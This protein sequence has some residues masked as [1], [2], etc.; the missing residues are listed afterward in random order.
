MTALLLSALS[1]IL[2][3][4]GDFWG[5]L[6][7]RQAHVLRALPT[8]LISGTITIF[9]LIPW[10]GAQYTHGSIMAGLVAGTFGSAGFF[11]VYRALAIG[12]MGVASAIVAVEA[13]AI[14]YFVGLLRGDSLTAVGLLG[15]VV[16]L[17]SILLVCRSTEDATHPASR[18][19]IITAMVAGV[20]VAGFFLG[21]ALAPDGSGMAPMTIT[22][23]IQ[24]VVIGAT[25]FFRRSKLGSEKPDFRLGVGAGILDALAA[26]AFI[27]AAHTGAL[28]VVAIVSNL[29]PAVTVLFAHF[30]LHERLERHQIV[31]MLGACG[32]VALL[33]LA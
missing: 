13:A 18:Q 25:A 3:G 1:A 10:L 24:T 33:T 16:A 30:Q 15:A 7:S 6:T 12:P 2:Y 4:I 27:V 28:S 5:G 29:Y 23:C 32:S 19:M 17:I 8:I 20:V 9:A 22:R 21:L 14:P 11:L 26:A 31:G